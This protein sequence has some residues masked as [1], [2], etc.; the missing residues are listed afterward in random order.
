MQLWACYKHVECYKHSTQHT[1]E[2]LQPMETKLAHTTQRQQRLR[3]R[4]RLAPTQR[5]LSSCIV[6]SAMRPLLGSPSLIESRGMGLGSFVTVVCTQQRHA[7]AIQ[8]NVGCCW[9]ARQFKVGAEMLQA[10]T[11]VH[12]VTV[13]PKAGHYLCSTPLSAELPRRGHASSCC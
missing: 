7:T 2:I 12:I 5:T 13:A 3:R 8:L 11:C 9:A 6:S 1:A 10:P 4:L